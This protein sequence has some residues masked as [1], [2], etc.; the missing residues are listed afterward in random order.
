MPVNLTCLVCGTPFRVSNYMGEKAKYCSRTCAGVGRRVPER[1]DRRPRPDRD[2]STV[3]CECATC[4][5]TLYRWPSEVKGKPAVYCSRACADKAKVGAGKGYTMDRGYRFVVYSRTE[6]IYEH[7]LVMERHL[8]RPLES[9][10]H[11]HHI[12]GDRSDNRIENL[13]VLTAAQH[14]GLHRAAWKLCGWSRR[15]V[16]CLSCGTTTTRHHGN[17]LCH[18]CYNRLRW[19]RT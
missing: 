1:R 6:R 7:R 13:Q 2:P 15:H 17:G 12:S 3:V 4:G 19:H 10:E 16:A 14:A 5:V 9:W 11:V 8:G 18:N